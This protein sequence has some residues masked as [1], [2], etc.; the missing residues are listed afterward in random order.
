MAR[1]SSRKGGIITGNVQMAGILHGCPDLIGKLDK[2]KMEAGRA[3]PLLPAEWE[4]S[5]SK[6]YMPYQ[7]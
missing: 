6:E 7:F 4:G 2:D 1:L 3:S 5:D